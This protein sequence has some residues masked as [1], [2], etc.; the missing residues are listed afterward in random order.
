MEAALQKT[1][2]NGKAHNIKSALITLGAPRDEI[3]GHNLYQEY[4][5][6]D[7]LFWAENL[8]KIALKENHPDH[9]T[10]TEYYTEK[11]I[12]INLAIY[13]IRKICS[14]KS[15]KPGRKPFLQEDRI[16]EFNPRLSCQSV[17]R[18]IGCSRAHVSHV[19][20]YLKNNDPEYIR[21]LISMMESDIASAN[22]RLAELTNNGNGK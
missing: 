6:A 7:I 14:N 12:K 3:I 13:K 17:A 16:K 5:R 4:N 18:K 20:R 19:R 10:E 22:E 1:P 2:P 9:P 11:L 8:Y 15:S 21:G